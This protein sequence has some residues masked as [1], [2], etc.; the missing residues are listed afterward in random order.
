[1]LFLFFTNVRDLAGCFSVLSYIIGYSSYT[2]LAVVP[3]AR[4]VS[5]LSTGAV[6][7]MTQI[8]MCCG[9]RAL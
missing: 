2:L 3:R 1:M 7:H 4:K 6:L 5:T 9:K 8:R